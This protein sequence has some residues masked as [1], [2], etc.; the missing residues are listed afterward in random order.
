MVVLLGVV[1][2]NSM[3][4]TVAQLGNGLFFFF[5]SSDSIG[6]CY[7]FE[8]GG[9]VMVELILGVLLVPVFIFVF[10][11]IIC[12]CGSGQ[13]SVVII[14]LTSRMLGLLKILGSM[15]PRR[16]GLR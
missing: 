2:T 5:L 7:L 4:K 8:I 3:F 16:W 13:R 12:T 6:N 14:R 11:V 9:V 10:S 1:L 15:L